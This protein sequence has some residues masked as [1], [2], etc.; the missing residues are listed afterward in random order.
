[1]KISA[2]FAFWAGL[3]FA[4]LCVGFAI[5]GFSQID[6]MVDEA[7]RSDARGFAY[8]FLF[9]GGVASVSAIVSWRIIRRETANPSD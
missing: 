9:L 1:M 7:A 4:V 5:N 2:Q 6:A 8:F 3:V